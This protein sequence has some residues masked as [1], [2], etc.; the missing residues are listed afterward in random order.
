MPMM[1]AFFFAMLV[2]VGLTGCDTTRDVSAKPRYATLVGREVKTKVTMWLYDR[3]LPSSPQRFPCQ[4]TE[5]DHGSYDRVGPLPVGHKVRFTK[6]ER[7]EDL[8]SFQEDLQGETVYRGRRYWI[9]YITY[10]HLG[11][12][13]WD[14]LFDIFDAERPPE[15]TYR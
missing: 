12:D 10:A 15:K 14:S 9:K 1:R 7:Y 13:S 3:N 11:P 2:M 5:K 8:F 4:L 6:V